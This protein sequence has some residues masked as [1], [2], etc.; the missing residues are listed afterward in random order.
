[1]GANRKATRK[2]PVKIPLPFADTVTG[3][4]AV[5][6]RAKKKPVAKAT[7]KRKK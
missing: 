6:P 5:K 2:P 7:G 1:M 4:L 3:L